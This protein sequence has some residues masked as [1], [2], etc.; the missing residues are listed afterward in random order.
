MECSIYL[1]SVGK[2]IHRHVLFCSHTNIN[3]FFSILLLPGLLDDAATI[4]RECGRFDMLNKLYQSA[5]LWDKAIT[6]ASNKDRIHLK[7]THYQYARHL[8]TLGLID[9]A[10][11]HYGLSGNSH[12]EVPRMLFQL[13]RV[14]ELGDFVLQS[15]DPV[16]LK[17]WA[18]YLESIER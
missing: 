16:L 2:V 4:F 12:T 1:V 9:D 17:W 7:T 11:E 8:E 14:D 10:I 6:T 15:D 5:G 18:A 13:D 3:C